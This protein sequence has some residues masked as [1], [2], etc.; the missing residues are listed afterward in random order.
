MFFYKLEF[1]YAK[2][3]LAIEKEKEISSYLLMN[4]FDKFYE[5]NEMIKD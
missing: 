1:Q 5:Q 2:V 4:D 3:I